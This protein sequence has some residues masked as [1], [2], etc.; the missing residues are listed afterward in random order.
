MQE[1]QQ[2]LTAAEVLQSRLE[3]GENVLTPPKQQS[4]WR[5]LYLF[6]VLDEETEGEDI[7]QTEA[8]IPACT[9]FLWHPF[10]LC[11]HNE[12]E[13]GIGYG[14]VELTRMTGH[15][16]YLLEDKSPGHIGD[17]SDNL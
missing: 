3:H 11:P 9:Y 15:H 2:G 16:I 6:G 17:F 8:E 14:F 4:K 5:F 7:R 13:H 10:M 12:E 1:K